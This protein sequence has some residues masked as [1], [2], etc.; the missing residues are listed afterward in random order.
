[1]L[2]LIA[3]FVDHPV[4]R[5]ALSLAGLT[6][7]I[8]F[9]LF[10]A[11]LALTPETGWLRLV[12]I[13][14]FVGLAGWWGRVFLTL[15]TLR[16]QPLLRWLVSVALAIG[17]VTALYAMLAFPGADSWSMI[18]CAISFAGVML[19]A[20][21]LASWQTVPNKSFKPKPFRGSA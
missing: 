4:T 16:K 3:K 12:G 14:G 5:V 18:M 9:G 11:V 17:V 21:T 7:T 2:N 20:G 19:V 1:M 15:A 13:G 8:L 10:A 6:V